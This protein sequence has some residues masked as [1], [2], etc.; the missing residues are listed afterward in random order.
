[1]SDTQYVQ[2]K[3][4][5]EWAKVFETNRDLKGPNGVFESHGGACTV[6]LLVDEENLKVLE[7]TNSQLPKNVRQ[8]GAEENGLFR[9]RFKRKWDAPY[10]Y[11][12]APQVVH[13]DGVTAWDIEEDGLIGNGS[14][15]V[16]LASVYNAKGLWGTRLDGVQVIDPVEYDSGDDGDYTP[17]PRFQD[18]SKS[19]APT[20]AKAKS[21]PAP[22]KKE[23]LEDEIPF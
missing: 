10:T 21:K 6:D 9:V 3:G 23:D 7:D 17:K 1:M 5:I 14:T 4:L 11:G 20:P 12:G 13:A 2:I 15:G 19:A 18:H 22:K 8:K 16:V